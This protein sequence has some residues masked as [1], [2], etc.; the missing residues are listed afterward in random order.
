MT[1]GD[2]AVTLPGQG[3]SVIIEANYKLGQPSFVTDDTS[4]VPVSSQST[5][6]YLSKDGQLLGHVKFSDA[7]RKKLVP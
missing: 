2:D 1:A 5:C 3:I 4:A 7:S 6:S